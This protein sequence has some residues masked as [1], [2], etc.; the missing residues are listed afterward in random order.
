MLVGRC[1][2]PLTATAVAGNVTVTQPGAPGDLRLFPS[3]LPLPGTSAINYQAAQTRANNIV[4]SLGGPGNV[5]AHCD[6][7]S[8][9]V[10]LILDLTGFVQ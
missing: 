10:H 5:T 9:T 1:G 2:I 4:L 7:A 3:G 6:Q 8:A